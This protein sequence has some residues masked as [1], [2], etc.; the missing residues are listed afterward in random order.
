MKPKLLDGLQIDD[1]CTGLYVEVDGENTILTF[2]NGR[3]TMQNTFIIDVDSLQWLREQLKAAE[4]KI[5]NTQNRKT[6]NE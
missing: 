3:G 1:F 4:Q 6:R 2:E 5:K